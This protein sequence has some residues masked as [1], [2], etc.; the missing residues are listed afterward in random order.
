M[1]LW[2]AGILHRD[3]STHNILIGR[4]GSLEGF[5][6][7]IIDLDLAIFTSRKHSCWGADFR[8]VDISNSLTLFII[9]EYLSR[10]LGHTNLSMF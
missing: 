5:R 8:T 7:V 9:T 2:R 3:V 10:G 6:G 1:N 4:P